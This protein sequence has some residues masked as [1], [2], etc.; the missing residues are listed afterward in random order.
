MYKGSPS[1]HFTGIY[2]HLLK[3]K[4]LVSDSKPEWLNNDILQVMRKRDAAYRRARKTGN[5]VE[6]RKAI[7][8]RN[9]VEIMI[10]TFKRKKIR[11][12]LDRYIN[13]PNKFWKEIRSVIPK[14]TSPIVTSLDDEVTG[15]TYIADEP[16]DHINQYFATI[17][18]ELANVIKNRQGNNVDYRP[19][20]IVHNDRNDGITSS[21]F[22]PDELRRA[23]KLIDVNKSS[24]L[25]NIRANVIID[26]YEIIFDRILKLYNQS[27]IS[28]KFP[29]S[30][31]TSIVVPIPKVNNPKFASDLRPISLISLPGKI[32]EHLISF[33]LKTYISQNNILTPNQH[34]FRKDHSTITSVTSLLHNI[35]NNV[36]ITKDTFLIYLDLKKAFD[37]VSHQI[38]INKI[39]NFGLDYRSINWFKSYLE[40]RQQYV[41]FNNNNS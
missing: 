27:L 14:E 24:A 5:E 25:C 33:R 38:L 36:N 11:D 9:R 18:E 15:I 41:K 31:K 28:A 34:G 32:L 39:G 37:T 13:N 21:L 1:L 7:V 23:M 4:L 17:G 29:L 26:T 2:K 8:L 40:N 6:W 16:S 10:K 30:W 20:A 19:Y 22:T 3:I 35:Y 12:N